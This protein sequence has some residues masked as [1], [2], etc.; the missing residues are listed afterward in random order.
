MAI[1]EQLDKLV[2]KNCTYKIS[3]HSVPITG[4][5]GKSEKS[6]DSYTITVGDSSRKLSF[7]YHDVVMDDGIIINIS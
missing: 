7:K 1:K 5:L 3:K 2:G 6:G 4:V